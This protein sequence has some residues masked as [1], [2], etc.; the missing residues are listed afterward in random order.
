MRLGSGESIHSRDYLRFRHKYW[1]EDALID[2]F[3]RLMDTYMT[4][5]ENLRFVAFGSQLWKFVDEKNI[6][7][8]MKETKG[9]PLHNIDVLLL[10]MNV[11]STHRILCVAFVSDKTF[12]VLDPYCH[13]QDLNNEDHVGKISYGIE[14]S[15]ETMTISSI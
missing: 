3:L 2:D 13:A 10:P 11:K 9:L 5:K 15:H 12:Q 1:L 7:A 6:S 14:Q 8:M 4:N